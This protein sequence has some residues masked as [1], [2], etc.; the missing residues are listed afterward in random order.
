[1]ITKEKTI[2]TFLRRNVWRRKN[3][4]KNN[5]PLNELNYLT[6]DIYKVEYV[7]SNS[8]NNNNRGLKPTTRNIE[9]L[10]FNDELS[11]YYTVERKYD[12]IESKPEEQKY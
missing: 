4:K 9:N 12:V 3:N 10:A 2:V 6:N 1:M 5:V 7:N 11:V 8:V